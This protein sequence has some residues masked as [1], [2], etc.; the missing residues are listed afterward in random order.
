MI[1][2][3]AE[4]HRVLGHHGHLFANIMQAQLADIHAMQAN[5][6]STD[7][8]EALQQLKQG[9]FTGAGRANYGDSFALGDL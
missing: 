4:Q 3:G 8:I 9:A 7:I 6:A 1:H 2:I 5:A